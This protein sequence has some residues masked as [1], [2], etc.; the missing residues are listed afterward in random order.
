MDRLN[1]T[2]EIHN[3][4]PKRVNVRSNLLVSSLVARIQDKF[5]LDGQYELRVKGQN[6]PLPANAPLDESGVPEGG[7]LVC[8]HVVD[9]SVT[10]NA[11]KRGVRVPFS[12][13][14]KRVYLQE[15][16]TLVEYDLL[17]HPAIL[18]RKDRRDPSKNRLLAVD[19]E[20]LEELPSVS[21]H[22]ACITEKDGKFYLEPLQMQNPTYIDNQK[23]RA[24]GQ[25][26][27]AGSEIQL[28]KLTLRLYL[29]S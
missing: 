26:L 1:L 8:L 14:F 24:S 27:S 10:A 2:L 23:V 9:V 15:E 3:V 21:R 16:R 28:G 7:T 11:I 13:K 29:I 19:L 17:W 12:K 6:K 5:N 22:H 18:G 20:D 25:Q 4:G